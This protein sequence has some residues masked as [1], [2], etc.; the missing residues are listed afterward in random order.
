LQYR[1]FK[2]TSENIVL[3]ESAV[4]VLHASGHEDVVGE[5]PLKCICCHTCILSQGVGGLSTIERRTAEVD[6]QN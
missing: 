4:T 3:H 2:V 1:H 5:G 6:G